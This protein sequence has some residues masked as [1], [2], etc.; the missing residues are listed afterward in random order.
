MATETKIQASIGRE[1]Y[2]TQINIRGHE[3]T[4]DELPDNG[5]NDI[6]PTPHE[7]VL[8]G[9][10]ACTASTL[11]MYVDR[12]GWPVDN[13]LIGVSLFKEKTSEGLVS[14]ISRTI[15][16]EGGVDEVQKQRMIE[17]ADKCSIQR[18]LTSPIIIKTQLIS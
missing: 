7:F 15:Q 14:H 18:M 12:K 17:I 8:A 1:R 13:I 9:L 2:K 11:R 10:A 4:G 3:L 16:I 6:G 5:G